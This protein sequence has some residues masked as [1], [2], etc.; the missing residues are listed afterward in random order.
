MGKLAT[1]RKSFA[2]A[3]D[4]LDLGGSDVAVLDDVPPESLVEVERFRKLYDISD[5]LVESIA[6]NMR[7]RG[8]DKTQPVLV[9]KNGPSGPVLLDGHTRK[10]AAIRAG[11]QAIPMVYVTADSE[12][13]AEGYIHRLQLLRRNLT[14]AQRLRQVIFQVS[15]TATETKAIKALEENGTAAGEEILSNIGQNVEGRAPRGQGRP[16]KAAVTARDLEKQMDIS[17]GSAAKLISV[18]TGPG[19]LKE[20]VLAGEISVNAAYN[21]LKDR[22]SPTAAE[23]GVAPLELRWAPVADGA[24]GLYGA[25]ASDTP[26][27]SIGVQLVKLLSKKRLKAL[28]DEIERAVIG[29]RSS[30]EERK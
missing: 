29:A 25:G 24:V 27:V 9:W 1:G 6:Q 15:H 14:D 2:A 7:T 23:E 30:A 5:E 4:F 17:R 16:P 8:Y 20:K 28:Q 12:D 22:T 11:L 21:E 18:A 10:R 19:D 3:M 26:D 13:E